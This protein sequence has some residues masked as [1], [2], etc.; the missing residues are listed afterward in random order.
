MLTPVILPPV[1]IT[2]PVS[3]LVG[4]GS[5][6]TFSASVAGT[7]PYG[8][9]WSRNG[10]PLVDDGVTYFGSTTSSLTISNVTTI[11][12]GT[13]VLTVSN[14]SGSASASATLTVIQPTVITLQPVGRSVPP[15]LPTIFNAS[16]SG[17]P[18]PAYQWQFNGTNI[19]G[20]TANIYS[21]PA[22]GLGDLGNYQVVA[23]NAGG[24]VTS[25]V[26]QLTFGPVAAWGRNFN[27]ESLP[28]PG[29]SN[30]IAIAGNSGAG[31]AVGTD[32]SVVSWGSGSFATATNRPAGATNV[33]ALSTGA[34]SGTAALRADGTVVGWNAQIPGIS[35]IVAV[36]EGGNNFGLALRV[37]GTVT[38]WGVI[39]Y[40]AP[41]AGLAHVTAIAAV[42][43]LIRWRCAM[44]A[45]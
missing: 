18:T 28:P 4:T 14:V 32:G 23:T 7:P 25:S 9:Q 5:N 22:V 45:P 34:D 21:N 38:N 37:E 12:T 33:V 8:Y 31:Y 2:P 16:A 1:I 20:A 30:V 3:Q 41:P 44:M 10:S 39:A 26:A 35:N 17:I 6:V 24:S 15:G 13:Y 36:A 29:L 19:L 40:G 43:T 42:A 27:N 11:Y